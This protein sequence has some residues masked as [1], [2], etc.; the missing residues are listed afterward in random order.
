[1]GTSVAYR[2]PSCR[3]CS[4]CRSGENLEEVSLIEDRE[5]YIIER[6]IKYDPGKKQLIAKLPFI[7][8]P[9][10]KLTEN[11]HI[12]KR[13]FST[14]LKK[15][16]SDENVRLGIVAAHKKLF[17]R[18]FICKLD[19]LPRAVK[20]EVEGL[21]GYTIPWRTVVKENSISTPVRLVFDAS[22]GTPGGESLNTILA[23]GSN[24]LGNLLAILIRF[25][26]KKCAFTA[27]VSMAYNGVRLDEAHL[28]YQKFLWKNEMRELSPL[29]IWVILTLI[30]GV[31]SS[32]NQTIEGFQVLGDV[33]LADPELHQACL[34]AAVLQDSA[35]MDDLASPHDDAE[36]AATAAEQ[37]R[38]V[39]GLGSMNV[40]DITFS[41]T[42]PSEL[43]STDGKNVGL[44]GML[45]NSYEDTI[46][47]NIGDL[48][49]GKKHRGKSPE[50]IEDDLEG[51]LSKQFTRRVIVG[52]VAGVYDPLG[53]LTPVTARYKLQLHDICKRKLDW[54]DDIPMELLKTW[55]D[56]ITEMQTLGRINFNRSIV[57]PDAANLR[58]SYVISSDASEEIAICSVHS[59]MLRTNGEYHVQ[60]VA[61]KSKIVTNLTVP[62][63]ELKGMVIGATLGFCIL[64]NTKDR[65]DQV[66]NVTDST[67]CLHWLQQDQRPLQTGVRNAVLEIR[68]LTSLDR[69]FHVASAD[70]VADIGTRRH[71]PP[72]I[73]PESEWVSGKSWMK[74]P[75]AQMPLKT[76]SDIALNSE[77]KKLAAEETKNNNINGIVLH[78]L[79]SKVSERLSYSKYHTDPTRFPWNGPVRVMAVAFRF[80][81]TLMKKVLKRTWQAPWFPEPIPTCQTEEDF[82]EIQRD[83]KKLVFIFNDFEISRAQNYFFYVAT[84]EVK[85]FTKKSEWKHCTEGK[86]KIL[87]FNSRIVEGQVVENALGEG[88]DVSPLMFVKPV[89][90]R[91]SPLAYALM[92]HSHACLARHRNVAET[93]RESRNIA[94]IFSARD[95]AIEIREACPFCR[96]YKA[97]LIQRE[98]GKLHDNRFVIA[99]P[100]Y[101][102]Q[103][104][105]FGPLTAIC[106][107]NHRSTVK[108]WGLVFKD[109]SCGAI[110]VYCMAK[111][112]T[113]AFVMAYTRHATRYGHPKRVV[114]D[115]GSQLVKAVN[116]MKTSL[117]ELEGLVKIQHQV[118][119]EFRVVPVGSHYQNGQV[120]RG[121]KEVRNLFSQVYSG[122][123]LDILAYE[124]AFAWCS[125]ELNSFP[126]C[127]GS[128]TD[129]LDNLDLITPSR[130]LYGR[131]NR[132][133]MSGHATIEMPSKVLDQME[134]TT[135]AWWKVWESQKIQD[136]ISQPR[137][138]LESGGTVNTGDIVVFLRGKK[139]LA[140]GEPVWRIGRVVELRQGKDGQCRELVVEYRNADEVVFRQVTLDSRQV[141]ILH[142]EGELE[143]VDILN[144]ASKDATILYHLTV[145]RNG[146]PQGCGIQIPVKNGGLENPPVICLS[147]IHI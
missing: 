105:M 89:V 11:L 8:N 4:S 141:A 77:Q 56:N 19:D 98:M 33:V 91:Y 1:M 124:T 60:L 13:V 7:Q 133:V 55:C 118:G 42:V 128:R 10:D 121:I 28:C 144:E 120:E 5:Q 83:S 107:H 59:R 23:K 49:L 57:P 2:C 104:D 102:V 52:K 95:L 16:S 115:A 123:R 147:L 22:S 58:I 106:E 85:Q 61:A 127:I 131:N 36:E 43:V 138:W 44:L 116:E 96:R 113:A 62:R 35:Y 48:Y 80:V 64:R 51:K 126:L 92:T 122:L 34:G 14:Q 17:D 114:I 32:G 40:K 45:W 99:P 6:S 63:A 87:Y 21:V 94:Y 100:F 71:I 132:R 78:N 31:K 137:K 109:P 145:G 103:C 135:R 75:T 67:I 136:Y 29:E 18:N 70:N 54:D 76:L 84:K 93:V 30:Y 101:G 73:S 111:Y 86:D 24:T 25:R 27:D 15:A 90:D 130:L 37:L 97:R 143:L 39:L 74:G 82:F 146:S 129:Q 125:N 3:N 53:L 117:L 50:K 142:H 65:V 108:V 12:A 69:W 68:R 38:Y 66:V 47:V 26:L 88:L 20:K 134:E 139:E 9:L 81:D 140:V 41:G 79:R 119:I 72:D 110:A 46:S 112:D